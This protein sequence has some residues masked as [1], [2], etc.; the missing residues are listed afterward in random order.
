MIHPLIAD[1]EEPARGRLCRLLT[2]HPDVAIVGE[3][4]SGV[5]TIELASHLKPNLI[6]LDIQMPG[7]TGL[8]IAASL[9][10][11]RPSIVFCTAYDE[12]AVDAFELAALDYLLK[13]VSGARLARALDRVRTSS[14]DHGRLNLDSRCSTAR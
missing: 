11:P 4:E 12:H 1:D 13:P 3:A 10:A 6:L 2:S 14:A 9:P 8:D 5:Q 7:C